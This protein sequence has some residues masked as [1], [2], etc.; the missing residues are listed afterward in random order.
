MEKTRQ[1]G[2]PRIEL[3]RVEEA[4]EL[5]AVKP[6]TVRAWLLRRKLKKVRVGSRAI[7]VPATEITR[8]IQE[9]EIPARER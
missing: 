9:G 1:P 2:S 3:L 6:S 4:A 5:L 7:R 8:I